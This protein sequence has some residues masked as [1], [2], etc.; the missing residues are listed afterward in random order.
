MFNRDK[1]RQQLETKLDTAILKI[2]HILERQNQL[3]TFFIITEPGSVK[4]AAAYDGLRKLHIAA[5][6]S[7]QTHMAQLAELH[8][9]TT[10]IDTP[11]A[12]QDKIVEYLNQAGI[13]LESNGQQNWYQTINGTPGN[14]AIFKIDEPAYIIPATNETETQLI[15]QGTGHW[16]DDTTPVKPDLHNKNSEAL[17]KTRDN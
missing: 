9:A 17:D 6:K 14:G 1:K 10:A 4:S 15:K 8:Y 7:T 13:Q 11:Q 2:E 3:E 12:L 5:N 16:R